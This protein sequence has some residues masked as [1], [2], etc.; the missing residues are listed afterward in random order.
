MNEVIKR[1]KVDE[2][3]AVMM[4][5]K[6]F[7]GFETTHRF[8]DGMY[9]RSVYRPAGVTVVGAL[10]KHEHFTV[11]LSGE[12]VVYTENGGSKR[13]YAGNVFVTPAGTKRAT[14]AVT[15]AEL[16]TIHRLPDPDERDLDKIEAALIDDEGMPRPYDASNKLRDPVLPAPSQALE[17]DR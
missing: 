9:C 17:T 8:A 12:I 11:I 3:Q 7:D 15:G 5:M 6:Q 14:Y 1:P 4:G 10:H 16:M 2:L 13:C